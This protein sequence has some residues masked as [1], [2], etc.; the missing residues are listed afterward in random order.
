MKVAD[1][2]ARHALEKEKNGL[3]LQKRRDISPI[4]FDQLQIG[5]EYIFLK[6]YDH[7]L[8]PYYTFLG[9]YS[10]GSVSYMF[11]KSADCIQLVDKR[12]T[13][14]YKKRILGWSLVKCAVKMLSLHQRAVVTA[15][16]PLRKLERG[17]FNEDELSHLP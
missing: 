9:E 8:S 14:F 10:R 11:R 4:K 2:L 6:S 1:Y 13:I 15:N 17:E 7:S 16:H 12:T 5:K 3:L